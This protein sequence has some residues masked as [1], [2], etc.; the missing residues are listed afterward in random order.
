[1]ASRA[2]GPDPTGE[3]PIQPEWPKQGLRGKEALGMGGDLGREF[4]RVSSLCS[5]TTE[6][7]SDLMVTRSKNDTF[8]LPTF[9]TQVTPFLKEDELWATDWIIAVC[10]SL[11]SLWGVRSSPL[12]EKRNGAEESMVSEV[13]ARVLRSIVRDVARLGG[14]SRPGFVGV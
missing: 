4:R 1:M 11:N 8:P 6:G 14:L 7:E 2:G 5:K 3:S 10:M 13:H 12:Q 9:R